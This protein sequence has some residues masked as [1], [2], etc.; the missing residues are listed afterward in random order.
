MMMS[1]SVAGL[2]LFWKAGCQGSY[3]IRNIDPFFCCNYIST[4]LHRRPLVRIQRDS[5]YRLIAENWRDWQDIAGGWSCLGWRWL[6]QLS[7]GPMVTMLP[8]LHFTMWQCDSVTVWHHS[9]VSSSLGR[10]D[11][12]TQ[13][14]TVWPVLACLGLEKYKQ[15]P[16]V[17]WIHWGEAGCSNTTSPHNQRKS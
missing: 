8:C 12:V 5:I 11:E 1:L 9:L 17:L 14:L 4:P 16:A 7:H 15:E 13:W 2:V 10:R 3:T 6:I